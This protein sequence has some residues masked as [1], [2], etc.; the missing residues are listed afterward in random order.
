MINWVEDNLVTE[1]IKNKY[2]M[3]N[4]KL[5]QHNQSKQLKNIHI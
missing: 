4:Y 2:Q 3:P 5:N 1:K